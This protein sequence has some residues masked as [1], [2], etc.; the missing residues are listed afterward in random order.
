M[1]QVVSQLRDIIDSEHLEAEQI[2][3]HGCD[4]VK[5][6]RIISKV[7]KTKK[8]LKIKLLFGDVICQS[9]MQLH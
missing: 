3:F 2:L 4:Y 8:T 9:L 1:K 7:L 5:Y 6:D